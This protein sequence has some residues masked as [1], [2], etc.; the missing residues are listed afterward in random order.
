MTHIQA[1]PKP[2]VCFSKHLE[3]EHK[4]LYLSLKDILE[5][6]DFSVRLLEDNKDIWMRDFMPLKVGEK[7]LQYRYEP[8]YLSKKLE[9]QTETSKPI[10]ELG[11]KA[12]K[13]DL[14]LDGGNAVM[15]EDTIIMTDKI[16]KENENKG[17][18]YNK[19]KN[20][21]SDFTKIVVI[22]WDKTEKYGH[23][24]GMVRFISKEHVLVNST[25]DATFK[26]K[27]HDS[28]E[29]NGL[30]VT[31]LK[32]KEDTEY[33]WGYIN[34]I[35]IRDLIIMP[36]IDK[37]NNNYVKEQLQSLFPQCSVEM[38]GVN[39]RTLLKKGGGLNCISWEY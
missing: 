24:D 1:K 33:A 15:Y 23:T 29:K 27:L 38:S 37:V 35:Q 18:D 5:S 11:I 36:D 39:T 26:K 4:D 30:K 9:Y 31:E 10:K 20:I 21:L 6:K 12:E 8:D 34:F 16:Y 25:Y 28:L 22:P 3:S 14:N 13:L 2:T 17:L 7:Y 32:L 19:L